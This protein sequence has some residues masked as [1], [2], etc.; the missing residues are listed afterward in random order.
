MPKTVA[1]GVVKLPHGSFKA[2]VQPDVFD[3]RDLV[4]RPRLQPLEDEVDRRKDRHVL[5][6]VGNSCTGHAAAAMV[7]ATLATR[8]DPVHV[9]PYM[10]YRFA[11][12]YDEFEGDED[13]GSSLRG[14][15]KGWYYHGV[16]PDKNWPK[17]NPADEPDLGDAKLTALAM[18][19]PLGAFYRVDIARLDDV[20]SAISEL[21]GI[22]ASA[23]IH[24]GWSTPTK[25][26]REGETM[27]VI[28]KPA[29]AADLG[30]HAFCIVGYNRVGFLVQ[31]SWGKQWG[32]LG[33][34]T[35][36]YDD[37]LDSAYDAWV[38][39][40]GVWSIVNQ[41]SHTQV[42]TV[43]GGRLADGPGPDLVRM[44]QHVVNLGNDGKL[45]PTGRFA[46]NPG[47]IER[48]FERMAEYHEFWAG[49][50]STSAPRRVVLYAHGGLNSE[51]TGLAI[52]SQ[53]LNWWL[54]NKVYPITFAWQTGPVET[55]LNQLADLIGR[56]LPAG[57]LGFNL[58][59]Q[60]DRLVEGFA[61]KSMRWMW[62]E[63]KEN[64]ALASTRIPKK[65]A[66]VWPP[67]SGQKGRAMAELPGASLT[68]TRLKHYIEQADPDLVEV[69][70]VAHSAGAIFLAG[71]L[72]RLDE[73]DIPVAS[74][75]YLAPAIRTDQWV[76]DVLRHL[77][78]GRVSRFASFGLNAE[79]EL[80]DVCGAGG[81]AVYQKSLLYLVS[82]ALERSVGGSGDVPLVG[83][84]KFANTAVGGTTL[85]DAVKKVDG[86]LVWSPAERP[87]S[88]RSDAT[89][90][91]GFD[92]DSPTMTSV[93]LR[94]LDRSTVAAGN[95]YV[96]NS[97]LSGPGPQRAQP[98]S[99]AETAPEP[100]TVA[101]QQ[102][103]EVP[104]TISA[105]ASGRAAAK[106]VPPTRGPRP[107][108]REAPASSSSIM[109]ALGHDGW[110]KVRD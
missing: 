43:T 79:R 55:L 69:H 59:E 70:L 99:D 34:A 56:R 14:V 83:M 86:M 57:G 19:R 21:N 35:L 4:Y 65:E 71:V 7:N 41:R 9:S 42:V 61:R 82:R 3:E 100:T 39:R 78:S 94:V 105:R 11:R 87:P 96:P 46:S 33:F 2:N 77:R 18:R 106:A 90:H 51:R 36:P 53:Q 10:L 44:A 29:G 93:M 32:R 64:A 81:V 50:S 28:E 37:W 8:K 62:D 17:L 30:G 5:T 40:P 22:V 54:N 24:E 45:S 6:Q 20:Q 16:L 107:E 101:V 1:P 104:V 49:R 38:A 91:G 102:A 95:T 27:Y 13:E 88:A 23:A 12:R 66:P 72:D 73:A 47:Q 92:D 76:Q 97:P 67:P 109:D 48:A 103:G 60:F 110:E 89:S 84:A 25:V 31:N 80:N 108:S 74:L 15:L 75:S 63:M 26:V 98:A 68:V 52:A 85:A 58:V